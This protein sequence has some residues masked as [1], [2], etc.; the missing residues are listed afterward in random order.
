[1]ATAV[2]MMKPTAESKLFHAAAARQEGWVIAGCGVDDGGQQ[3]TE[4]QR[5]DNPKP[6][7]G[8]FAGDGDAWT[9][10]AE[11]ARRGSRL[12]LQALALVD[13]IERALI[14]RHARR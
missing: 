10:V 9:R 6:G 7:E 5:L 1:M 3:W 4:L 12:H 11:Q 8:T 13:P 14:E 2:I